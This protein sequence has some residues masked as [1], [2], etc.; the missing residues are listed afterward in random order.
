MARWATFQLGNLDTSKCFI[1]KSLRSMALNLRAEVTQRESKGWAGRQQQRVPGPHRL[2]V[3]STSYGSTSA[4]RRP[5]SGAES[6]VTV[7]ALDR[8]REAGFMRTPW[9][10]RGQGVDAP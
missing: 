2:R 10:R 9:R 3:S 5:A 4:G 1:P 8:A 6:S 7:K